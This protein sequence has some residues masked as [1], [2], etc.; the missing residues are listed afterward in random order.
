M[1]V[2]I[3]EKEGHLITKNYVHEYE[4]FLAPAMN[5]ALTTKEFVYYK[6]EDDIFKL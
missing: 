6:P 4:K 1:G 5:A 2:Y 3:N